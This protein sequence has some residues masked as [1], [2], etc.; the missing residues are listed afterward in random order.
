MTS[1]QLF[2]LWKAVGILEDNDLKVM[3]VTSDGSAANRT[4]C[5][6]HSEMK[7]TNIDK[8][9]VYKTRNIYAEDNRDIFF[10]CDEPHVVKTALN[11][12][13]HSGF[14][15]NFT[16]LLW[17]SG[18]YITWSHIFNLMMEDL[19]G[20]LQLCPKITTEH[21]QLTP[22]SLMN[23]RIAA[24]VLSSS[25]SIALKSFGP[26]EAAGTALYCDMFD[27][28]FDCL[29]V[30]N[31]TEYITKQKPFLNFI[32]LLMMNALIGSYIRFYLISR[33][34]KNQLNLDLGY[35]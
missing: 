27:K 18:Y 32:F 4:M 26:Q 25:V 6:M 10:I 31:C 33:I 2:P 30:R 12:V 24:Q 23:V 17:N 9:V 22:F 20:S 34:G 7:H 28:F 35:T 21:I 13:A 16:K 11:N 8:G 1:L 14:N 5:R 29:H 3:A 19:E 15:N